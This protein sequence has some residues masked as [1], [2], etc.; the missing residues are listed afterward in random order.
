ML[1]AAQAVY[2]FGSFT[3]PDTRPDSDI[4][5]A[6]LLPTP[7]DPV[8]RWELQEL[9]ATRQ[10]RDVDLVDLR[11]ASTVM[12][13]QVVQTGRLLHDGSPFDRQLFEAHTLSD[14]ADLQ[15]RRKAILDDIAERGT[16]T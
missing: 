11:E 12:R 9:L 5:L 16:V 7:L 2:L 15:W 14:Y 1:P 4:D 10:H 3:G 6:V 8:R 13:H